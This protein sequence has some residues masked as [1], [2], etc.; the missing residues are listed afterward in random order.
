MNQKEK[1]AGGEFFTQGLGFSTAALMW[2]AFNAFHFAKPNQ[3]HQSNGN[4]FRSPDP[5][6]R[7]D[8]HVHTGGHD[9]MIGPTAGGREAVER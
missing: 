4:Q 3:S 8:G 9:D 5:L 6:Q 1:F 7:K 2:T